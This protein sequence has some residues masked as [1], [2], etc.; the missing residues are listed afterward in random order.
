MKRRPL[1]GALAA[2]TL[3]LLAS[4]T[5]ATAQD[6]QCIILHWD[7]MTFELCATPTPW[8]T[9]TP[10]RT[11]TLEPTLTATPS[12]TPTATHTPTRTPTA[13]A[14][15]EP[16]PTQVLT[17][18]TLQ[19]TLTSTPSPTATPTITPTPD[20]KCWGVTNANLNVRDLPSYEWLGT[21]PRGDTVTLEGKYLY[22]GEWWYMHFWL[23]G[24]QGY[25]HSSY[26]EIA[27]EADCSQLPDVTPQEPHSAA[28]L[29][30]TVPSFNIGNARVSYEVLRGK[31]IEFGL[32]TYASLD[33]A[34]D[35]LN[36][37]GI[38]IYRHGAPDCPNGIGV[39]DPRQSARDFLQHGQA[40]RDNLAS[41]EKAYY[42][43][44]NECQY[45]NSTDVRYLHWWAIF[46]DEYFRGHYAISDVKLVAPTL[47]PGHGELMMWIVWKT[48]L[49]L[50][51]SHGGLFGEHAYAPIP[52][53]G[54]DGSLAQCD[55]YCACRHRTNEA[56]RQS[57]GLD[58]DV[59]ITEAARD[60]G[61]A[62]VEVDDFCTWYGIVRGDEWLHSVS[63]WT[64]GYHPT[65][66]NANLDAYMVP[67]AQC[68]E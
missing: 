55:P 24:I 34:L 17:L 5:L 13:T 54:G 1:I 48:A 43:P 16:T 19:P 11:A 23:P 14:T 52:N 45:G 31:D 7:T 22:F 50:N 65:W 35:A 53:C 67:I 46:L 62:P 6:D 42:E 2:I 51:A 57:I 36:R 66:P 12:S 58:I 26:I 9:W 20:R 27:P 49:E 40:A 4:F 47:G 64:A 59:A 15:I 3:A 38:A 30:H 39:D 10:E 18:T 8:P 29:Y 33:A 56:D 25:S 41:Y 21:I 68:V 44:F 60:F 37:G 61:N 63:L 28:L 32:K